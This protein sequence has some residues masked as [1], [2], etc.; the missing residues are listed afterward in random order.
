M[1]IAN[2]VFRHHVVRWRVGGTKRDIDIILIEIKVGV[3]AVYLKAD[4]WILLPKLL[5]DIE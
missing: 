3:A 5:A 2:Q 4:F 1:L